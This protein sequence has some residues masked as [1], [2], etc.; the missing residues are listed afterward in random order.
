MSKSRAKFLIV[1]GDKFTTEFMQ[2][3]DVFEKSK[4]IGIPK[5]ITISFK[6]GERVSLSRAIPLIDATRKALESSKELVSLIHLIEVQNDNV[7]IKNRGEIAPYVNR[8]VRCISDGEKWGL[9]SKYIEASTGLE[10]ITDQHMFI[11]AVGIAIKPDG[12]G[13]ITIKS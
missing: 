8:E 9:F 6:E 1:S 13:T 12:F 5:I 3:A 11:V 7:V 10:V 2:Y 4:V